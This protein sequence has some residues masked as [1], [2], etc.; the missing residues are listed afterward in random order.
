MRNP[1]A[2]EYQPWFWTITA[3]AFL[4]VVRNDG[5]KIEMPH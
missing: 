1:Q 2:P 4:Y 3:G 5:I